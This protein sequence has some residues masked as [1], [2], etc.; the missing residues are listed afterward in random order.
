MMVV[1]VLNELNVVV[2]AVVVVTPEA[3]AGNEF[4][5]LGDRLPGFDKAIAL[6]E[7]E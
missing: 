3:Q 6:H 7:V 5:G 2:V 1:V 4:V